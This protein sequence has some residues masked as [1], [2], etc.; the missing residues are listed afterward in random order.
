MKIVFAGSPELALPS[1]EAAAAN[2]KVLWVLT[3]PDKPSGRGKNSIPT[4]VKIKAVE[5]GLRVLCRDKLDYSDYTVFA[6]GGADILVVVAYGKIFPERFISLFPQ[7]GINL[8]P[9]LLPL[10]RGPSPI[11]SAIRDGVKETGI[12]IQRLAKKMDTGDIL[13]QKRVPLTGLETTETLSSYMAVQGAALLIETLENLERG[14]AVSIP[15]TEEEA[16]YCFLISKEEALISWNDSAKEIACRVRA[17]YPWPKAETTLRG[18]KLF[19]LEAKEAS[20]VLVNQEPCGTVVGIDKEE[21]I[22]VQTG[23]GILAVR[24]LQLAGK[25]P[26][27]WR[28]FFNGVRDLAGTLLGGP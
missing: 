14:G 21:G 3:N 19:I 25:N 17:F 18:H 8:H 23:D 7:G 28:E 10:Y 12:T 5:L 24:K 26:L 20:S 16:S 1:L 13:A 6:Q 22:L 9:S 4:P 15:Q 2:H 27:P 11:A